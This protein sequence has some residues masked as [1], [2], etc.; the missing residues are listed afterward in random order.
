[1]KNHYSAWSHLAR[2]RKQ[3]CVFCEL[4]CACCLSLRRFHGTYLINF[5]SSTQFANGR[6]VFMATIL[7]MILEIPSLLKISQEKH[8]LISSV[9]EHV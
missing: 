5:F 8:V 9:L 4:A 6:Q 3:W 7:N 1:M 2:N